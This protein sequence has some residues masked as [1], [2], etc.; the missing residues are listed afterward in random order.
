R[1][2]QRCFPAEY[3]CLEA[4]RVRCRYPPQR[5]L[6][7]RA[8]TGSGDRPSCSRSPLPVQSRSA[9]EL[10]VQVAD[11]LSHVAQRLRHLVDALG[12]VL[13]A[14][15]QV[16]VAVL[17]LAGGRLGLEA[18]LDELVDVALAL[19]EGLVDAVLT[20]VELARAR[21]D[22]I[23][24]CTEVGHENYLPDV[25][26]WCPSWTTCI[27]CMDTRSRGNGEHYPPTPAVAT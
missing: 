25:L 5:P 18:V 8:R 27:Y 13:E 7:V 15:G 16:V 20:I 26:G 17:E 19:F 2:R 10:V 23:I 1:T 3:S 9:G 24:R 21:L 6:P 4:L 22:L 12:G 14:L 11:G